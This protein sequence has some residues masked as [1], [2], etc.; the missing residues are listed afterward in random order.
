VL[1]LVLSAQDL[2]GSRSAWKGKAEVGFTHL[3]GNVDK[4]N[5]VTHGEV[6]H[7]DSAFELL[8]VLGFFYGEVSGVKDEQGGFGEIRYDYRP[9]DMWS[10]FL[11][12][13]GEINPP[14]GTDLRYNGGVGLK[15]SALKSPSVDVSLSAAVLYE[16][17]IFTQRDI[18]PDRSIAR[19]S[20]RI[21]YVQHLFEDRVVIRHATFYQPRLG[22]FEE[23][24]FR[25]VST[26]SIEGKIFDPIAMK[27]SFE[28]TYQEFVQPGI[29]KNDTRLVTSLVITFN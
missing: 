6:A 2:E 11:F 19:L 20:L 23:N 17:T 5:F 10:P 24:D 28:D 9:Q 12:V 25:I 3:S 22:K 15:Y 4:L 8:L 18:V 1:P 29:K 13:R 26:T 27:I 14:Q 7:A 16:E 21:K